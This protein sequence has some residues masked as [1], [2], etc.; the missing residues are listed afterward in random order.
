MINDVSND[1]HRFKKIFSFCLKLN[2]V[3]SIIT[4]KKQTQLLFKLNS[5]SAISTIIENRY[6]ILIYDR[7][8]NLVQW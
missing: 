7:F 2:Q 3:D 5:D 1:R 4:E 8:F 6:I